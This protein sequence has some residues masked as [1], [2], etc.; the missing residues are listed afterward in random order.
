MPSIENALPKRAAVALAFLTLAGVGLTA[1]GGSASGTASNANAAATAATATAPKAATTTG[2]SKTPT[3]TTPA[4]HPGTPGTSQSRFLAIRECLQKNGV[5][6]PKPAQGGASGPRLPSG[7]TRARL[8]A[9]LKKCGSGNAVRA[10]GGPNAPGAP[11]AN[12]VFRQALA[13][14]A[15]CLRQNGVKIPAPDTSGKGPIF[16][17]KGLNTGSPQ[18]RTATIKCRATLIGAFRRPPRANGAAGTSGSPQ[19]GG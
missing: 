6:L 4:S 5:T 1:C 11:A 8:Q 9:A 19:G 17:T 3:S 13:K 7:F 14:Y 10:F 16:N 2:A 12:P 18:F 15:E